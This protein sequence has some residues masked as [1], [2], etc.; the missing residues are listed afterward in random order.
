[1][2]K[3]EPDLLS[4][5]NTINPSIKLS[6]IK[7]EFEKSKSISTFL[8]SFGANSIVFGAFKLPSN[9]TGISFL[10]PSTINSLKATK[11][12]LKLNFSFVIFVILRLAL[13]LRL[14]NCLS[15]N[16]PS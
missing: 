16:L 9:E 12:G 13:N 1:M 6:F 14:S 4:A 15:S 8:V 7:F 5:F 3:S 2:L 10:N 11:L